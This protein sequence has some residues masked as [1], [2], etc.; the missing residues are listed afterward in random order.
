MFDVRPVVCFPAPQVFCEAIYRVLGIAHNSKV[1][2][3][4]LGFHSDQDSY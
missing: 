3:C 4:R 1:D 2:V